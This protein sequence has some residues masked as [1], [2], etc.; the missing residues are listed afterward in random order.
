[1]FV[2][3]LLAM[4]SLPISEYP[5]VVPPQVVVRA[6]YPGA[7]PQCDRRNRGDAD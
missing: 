5:E 7:N 6:T 2:A 4:L 3:G 1:M